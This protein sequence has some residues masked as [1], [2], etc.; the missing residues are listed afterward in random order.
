[1]MMIRICE[2]KRGLSFELFSDETDILD[3]NLLVA[4]QVFYHYFRLIVTLALLLF[5][6][7]NPSY[8]P[9]LLHSMKIVKDI[10]VSTG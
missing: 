10:K 4:H 7:P 1:M 3:L 8:F 5:A 2:Y 6:P 9:E